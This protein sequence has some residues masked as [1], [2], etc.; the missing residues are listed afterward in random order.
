MGA[1]LGSLM[2]CEEHRLRVFENRLLVGV[3]ELSRGGVI[4][5][6]RKLHNEHVSNLYSSPNIIRMNK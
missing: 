1:K 2:S 6:S 5:S 3:F 4:G